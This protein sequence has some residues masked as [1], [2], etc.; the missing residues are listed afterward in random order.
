[1]PLTDAQHVANLVLLVGRLVR[2]VRRT[3]P[4]NDVAEK[5]MDY[6]RRSD[7]MPS[8][9]R[10]VDESQPVCACA[11]CKAH[12][13]KCGRLLAADGSDCIC[14]DVD[15]VDYDPNSVFLTAS[16]IHCMVCNE[17]VPLGASTCHDCGRSL[18]REIN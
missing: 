5:A 11:V 13:L 3:D 10:G 16:G 9:T 14:T 1:M 2:Q 17:L 8:I 6:L 15:D 18:V 7:L 4:T 12:C